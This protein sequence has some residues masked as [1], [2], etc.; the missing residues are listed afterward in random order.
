MYLYLYESMLYTEEPINILRVGLICRERVI[1]FNLQTL[2]DY[3]K[4]HFW[5][6]GG[7]ASPRA[8]FGIETDWIKF[9]VK[10]LNTF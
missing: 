6:Y 7:T 5:N 10:N 8:D 1:F 2:E 9:S 4:D 3:L